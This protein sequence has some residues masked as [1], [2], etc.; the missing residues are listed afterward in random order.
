MNPRP[1]FDPPPSRSSSINRTYSV[2]AAPPLALPAS[3]FSAP[4]PPPGTRTSFGRFR[5]AIHQWNCP[6]RQ[7]TIVNASA[8]RIPSSPYGFLN[9]SESNPTIT[10][11]IVPPIMFAR[12]PKNPCAVA[13]ILSGTSDCTIAPGGPAMTMNNATT[14]ALEYVAAFASSTRHANTFSGAATTLQPST[15]S[16]MCRWSPRE[17]VVR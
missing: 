7:K 8:Y 15:N 17:R 2:P 1:P 12:T 9:A 10:G 5:V 6:H 14:T 3:P 11:P 4:S 16:S 13:R